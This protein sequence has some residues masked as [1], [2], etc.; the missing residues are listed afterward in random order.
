MRWLQNPF[1]IN[2]MDELTLR[3]VSQFYAYVEERQKVHCLNTLFSKVEFLFFF[4]FLQFLLDLTSATASL[5][6]FFS[7]TY[8]SFK[9]INPS[10]FATPR[11]ELNCWQRRSPNLDIR[12]FTS[13]PR[14][15][16]PT[17]TGSFTTFAMG[18]AET[19]CA[20][21]LILFHFFLSGHSWSFFLN[22]SLCLTS[23]SHHPRY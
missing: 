11:T 20:Q 23:R 19:L 7:F 21:V 15:S 6:V 8:L 5:F 2:L 1:E 9:S 22:I 13:T 12:A 16:R 10:S 17:A 4:F 14:C 3:G 18:P